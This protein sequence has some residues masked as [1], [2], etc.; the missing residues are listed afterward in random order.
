M[1]F[2]IVVAWTNYMVIFQNKLLFAKVWII[3]NIKD[4]LI[5]GIDYLSRIWHFFLEF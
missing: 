5:P 1:F 4:F 2:N 3:R